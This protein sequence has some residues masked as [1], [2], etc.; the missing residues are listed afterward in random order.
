[1]LTDWKGWLL[2]LLLVATGYIQDVGMWIERLSRIKR[3][4]NL[5]F[6]H[7]LF[8]GVWWLMLRWG[9]IIRI[10][11]I[12]AILLLFGWRSAAFSVLGIFV[13]SFALRSVTRRHAQTI[14]AP[15]QEDKPE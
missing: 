15:L 4:D 1:M 12:A 13:I 9:G 5:T 2:I 14:L 3:L 11:C 8:R 7:L 6:Y 10:V